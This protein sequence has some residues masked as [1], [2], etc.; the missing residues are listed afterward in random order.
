MNVTF[1]CWV[2]L[3]RERSKLLVDTPTC[4]LA[5]DGFILVGSYAENASPFLVLG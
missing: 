1:E 5:V 4:L 2:S 3:I